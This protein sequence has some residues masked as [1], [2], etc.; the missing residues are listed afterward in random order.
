MNDL[1]ETIIASIDDCA[2]IGNADDAKAIS[3]VLWRMSCAASRRSKAIAARLSGSINDALRHE[4]Q[5]ERYIE[6]AKLALE[7]TYD[8]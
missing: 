7:G 3:V 5:S 6:L 8:G 2:A 1:L 4:R